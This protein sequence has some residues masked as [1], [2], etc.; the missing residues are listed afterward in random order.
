[1]SH[2]FAVRAV[3]AA[4]LLVA[5]AAL[6]SSPKPAADAMQKGRELYTSFCARCHGIGMVTTGASF[7]LRTFPRDQ[8]ERFERSVTQGL[9]AMPAWGATFRP[10]ELESL[11][12]YISRSGAG[13]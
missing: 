11:W 12:L 9:R 4:M 7:D 6:A 8:R 1:M 13:S 3:V 2:A 10:D 5:A